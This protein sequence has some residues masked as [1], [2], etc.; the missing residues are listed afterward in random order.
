MQ[1]LN[2]QGKSQQEQIQDEP[3]LTAHKHTHNTKIKYFSQL[4]TGL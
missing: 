2:V 4:I 3:C 1:S